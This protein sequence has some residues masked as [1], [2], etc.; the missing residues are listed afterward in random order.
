MLNKYD[1]IGSDRKLI[2]YVKKPTPLTDEEV[3]DQTLEQLEAYINTLP[4]V[5]PEDINEQRP[6]GVDPLL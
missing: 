6:G 1:K 3:R 2:G 5:T 4:D